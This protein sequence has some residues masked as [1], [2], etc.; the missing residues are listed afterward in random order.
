MSIFIVL[1]TFLLG[2][3]SA[4]LRGEQALVKGPE[5]FQM[6]MPLAVHATN[7]SD[8][9]TQFWKEKA[10]QQPSNDGGGETGE[11]GDDDGGPGEGG[12]GEGGPGGPGGGGDADYEKGEGG[13]DGEYGDDDFPKKVKTT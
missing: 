10:E 9:A 5:N 3:A 1:C 4:F 2:S 13:E 12:P 6:P 7:G 11:P 8:E